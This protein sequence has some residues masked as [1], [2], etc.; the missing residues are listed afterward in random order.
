MDR[1]LQNIQALTTLR[2]IYVED[3]S[4][5]AVTLDRIGDVFAG[6]G[7]PAESLDHYRQ[8]LDVR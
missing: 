8:A 7:R 2:R 3:A 6:E 4:P 1:D 5:I